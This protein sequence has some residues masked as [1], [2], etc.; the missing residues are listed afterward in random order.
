MKESWLQNWSVSVKPQTIEREKLVIRR[1]GEIIG[2]DYLLNKITPMLMRDS[3]MT[4]A[5]I[6]DASHSTMTHYIEHLFMAFYIM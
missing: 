1:L 5:R 3:L 4:Y 6:Y 2:D